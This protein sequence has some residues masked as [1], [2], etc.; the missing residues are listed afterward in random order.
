MIGSVTGLRRF[1][2]AR[3]SRLYPLYL[4][5]LLIDL[6]VAHPEFNARFL[7]NVDYDPVMVISI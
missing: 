5:L 6:F 4:A 3:F 2:V 7:A 1:M